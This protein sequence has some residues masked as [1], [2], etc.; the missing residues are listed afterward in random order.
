MSHSKRQRKRKKE[1]KGGVRGC[2]GP[3]GGHH[4]FGLFFWELWN[5]SSPISSHMEGYW[6]SLWKGSDN[7]ENGTL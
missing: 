7:K 1:W 6:L 4:S 5:Y 3:F 2:K